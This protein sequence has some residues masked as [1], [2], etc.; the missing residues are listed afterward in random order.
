MAKTISNFHFDYWNPSLKTRPI[1][2][3]TVAN[4]ISVVLYPKNQSLVTEILRPIISCFE[5][6]ELLRGAIRAC[7]SYYQINKSI[8]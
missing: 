2:N 6:S 7:C 8:N 1:T 3:A 5:I 4:V